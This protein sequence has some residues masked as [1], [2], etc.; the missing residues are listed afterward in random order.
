[1]G[2]LAPHPVY[3]AIL[4]GVFA[5][6][7]LSAETTIAIYPGKIS[8]IFEIE[9][10][11]R[12]YSVFMKK[13]TYLVGKHRDIS[14]MHAQHF[15]PKNISILGPFINTT[16]LHKYKNAT[17]KVNHIASTVSICAKRDIYPGEEILISYGKDFLI[18]HDIQLEP[19][20][21]VLDPSTLSTIWDR[22]M[23]LLS[24]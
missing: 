24:K 5:L 1:L 23:L 15:A 22:V 4:G 14:V 13:D 17:L 11:E 20:G 16:N 9:N 8:T 2:Y 19:L 3:P 12:E 10:G 21:P 18:R 6:K 7:K